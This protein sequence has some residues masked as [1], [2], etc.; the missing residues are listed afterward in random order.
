MTSSRH[1][2]KILNQ[3]LSVSLLAAAASFARSSA[4]I[5]SSFLGDLGID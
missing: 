4:R 1:Y 5:F 2:V 3:L